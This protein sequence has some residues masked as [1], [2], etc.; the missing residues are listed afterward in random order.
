MS[1]SEILNQCADKTSQFTLKVHVVFGV[2]TMKLQGYHVPGEPWVEIGYHD[3]IEF[4]ERQMTQA[5]QQAGVDMTG[6]PVKQPGFAFHW[7]IGVMPGRQNT[8]LMR[9]ASVQTVERKRQSAV[10]DEMH[11]AQ[12][13][14]NGAATSPIFDSLP[15]ELQQAIKETN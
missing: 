9:A 13:L 1:L 2:P 11:T 4:S 7:P 8:R 10:F 6:R 15:A 5:M 14:R 12:G 3:M